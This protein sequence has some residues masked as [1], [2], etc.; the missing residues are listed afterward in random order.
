V[1]HLVT[2]KKEL[3][4][5]AQCFQSYA[6]VLQPLI[7]ARSPHSGVFVNPRMAT[8]TT[9]SL[10]ARSKCM[11][12]IRSRIAAICGDAAGN[13]TPLFCSDWMFLRLACLS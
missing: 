9:D 12:Q 3:A 10:A 1:L 2:R 13:L 7:F 4:C 8:L 6:V 11:R 5:R